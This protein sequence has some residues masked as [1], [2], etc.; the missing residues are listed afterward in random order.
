MFS[1]N[2]N[3]ISLKHLTIAMLI[4][5]GFFSTFLLLVTTLYFRDAALASQTKSLSRVVQVA[6]QEVVKQIYD[7]IFA[8][9]TTLQSHKDLQ[10]ALSRMNPA[11]ITMALD[12]P[13]AQGLPGIATIDLV[14]L[15]IYDP[16]LE[17]LAESS[18]GMQGLAPKMDSVL[19]AQAASRHGAERL[20]AIAGLWQGPS[21]PLYSILLPLGGL[22]VIAYLEIIVNPAFNLPEVA[23]ITRLPL[24][25]YGANGALLYQTPGGAAGKNSETLNIEYILRTN[26]GEPAYRLVSLE[27]VAQMNADMDKSAAI[28]TA[29]FMT[30]VVLGILVGLWFFNKF[31]FAP[32]SSM[33]SEMEGIVKGDFSATVGENSLREFHAL[34]SAFNIMARTVAEHIRQLHKLSCIDGLTNINNR[35]QFDQSLQTEWQRA[36]RSGKELSLIILDIDYFKQ[37]NDTYGHIGGDDCLKTMGRLLSSVVHR[38]TDMVARYGGEEFVVLMSETSSEGVRQIAK[39]IADG[40]AGLN[41]PHTG[42]KISDK[43]TV[44]MGCVTCQSP[45][46][47]KAK[48]LVAAADAALYRAKEE[49]RNRFIEVVLAL[50]KIEGAT[51]LMRCE[52]PA[53]A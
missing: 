23:S 14:K 39:K 44:S 8:I 26:K 51:P 52:P 36:Q 45:R 40:L 48:D 12:D 3:R 16:N 24:T 1:L 38:P 7:K 17:L 22:R 11:E 13:F 4:A 18:L 27:D 42:S 34:A 49:G 28:A 29:V 2:I 19:Q 47:F 15:R 37:Y 41:L 43:L 31:L 46:E 50:S 53:N 30:L 33:Q 10:A 5:S 20:K 9:G 21:G 25:L 6:S 32:M 35:R